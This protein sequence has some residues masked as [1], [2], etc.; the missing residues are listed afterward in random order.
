MNPSSTLPA[1]FPN[2]DP[3]HV[4]ECLLLDWMLTLGT[5]AK[6]HIANAAK[7]GHQTNVTLFLQ[8]VVQHLP[9]GSKEVEQSRRAILENLQVNTRPERPPRRQ[10]VP[11]LPVK[12]LGK[13]DEEAV[14][15]E[16]PVNPV[17][18]RR[19]SA[20][21]PPIILLRARS[22]SSNPRHLHIGYRPIEERQDDVRQEDLAASNPEIFNSSSS[23]AAPPLLST[24][25]STV[26]PSPTV[27]PQTPVPISQGPWQQRWDWH[28]ASQATSPSP[29]RPSTSLR[30]P[31]PGPP[32]TS[33]TVIC[34]TSPLSAFA[35]SSPRTSSSP[36]GTKR[37]RFQDESDDS[38]EEQ[39]RD[40]RR[41]SAPSV[42]PIA[43]STPR[44]RKQAYST[45]TSSPQ[46]AGRSESAYPPI[47][48]VVETA[49]EVDE[50]DEDEDSRSESGSSP[51][52]SPTVDLDS[53]RARV[54]A[55]S[56]RASAMRG[57]TVPT[58]TSGKDGAGRRSDFEDVIGV[59]TRSAA[60][61][62]SV[63]T[64]NSE[65]GLGIR[66]RGRG[67]GRR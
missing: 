44:R 64:T 22:G 46:R 7:K 30:P 11:L 12:R 16:A 39:E 19:T 45:P 43:V 40:L 15:A 1:L 36:R 17:P 67:R 32:P 26:T 56:S 38:E 57:F 31:P 10:S 21:S 52:T 29:E 48:E 25:T 18:Q 9:T 59:V 53:L 62:A 60:A 54:R 61:A 8:D 35:Q 6:R 55:N 14:D 50:W 37:P 13:E 41:G 42:Q 28:T 49:G 47:S 51:V 5:R 34:P 27:P 3:G 66:G 23:P 33:P 65:R 24:S 2:V 63:S 4:E 20:T 58:W